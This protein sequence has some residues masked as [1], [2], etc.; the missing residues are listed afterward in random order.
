MT[1]RYFLDSEETIVSGVG[2]THFGTLHFCWLALF[3]LTVV[4]NFFVYRKLDDHGRTRWRKIVALTLGIAEIIKILLHIIGGTF[5]WDY[6]PLHLCGINI[7]L[8]LIHAYR[9][10]KLLNNFLYTVCI[11]GAMAAILFPSWTSL[12][13]L[14]VFHIHSSIAHILLAMYPLVP[15]LNGD[16]KPNYKMMAKCLGLLALMAIPIY[17]I[18]LLLDTNFMFLMYAAPNNPLYWFGQNW[19]SHLLGFPVIIAGVMIV[20][21]LPMEL[22]RKL[23]KEKEIPKIN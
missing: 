8:I 1:F 20:M 5:L 10:S 6:L 22:Y 18:N 9:P 3:V 13:L 19:G 16:M 12:P 23:K 11:P 21:Y 7:F 2:F 15:A 14:N 4:I 17:G